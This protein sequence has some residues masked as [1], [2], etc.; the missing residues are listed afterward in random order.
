VISGG[1]ITLFINQVTSEDGEVI[2][3]SAA[4]LGF[5]ADYSTDFPFNTIERIV[6]AIMPKIDLDTIRSKVP[7]RLAGDPLNLGL[8]LK[9]LLTQ[10][11]AATDPQDKA[12]YQS[13][14]EKFR[15]R[16]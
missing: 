15:D 1:A 16:M 14:I 4:A 3:L 9:E 12:L 8:G 10:H 7:A 5:I 13:L 11:A 2:H 6:A